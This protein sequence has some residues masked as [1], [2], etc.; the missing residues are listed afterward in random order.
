MAPP[1]VNTPFRDPD[2]GSRMVRVTDANTLSEYGSNFT[3]LSFM[4]D[5]SQEQ[6]T[7]GVFDPSLGVSGG[8]RFVVAAI[9][10]GIVPYTLD[11]TTMNVSRLS[12]QPGS[13]LN[14]YGTFDFGSAAFSYVNPDILYGVS[15]TRLVAY[16]FSIGEEPL[17]YDFANCPGLPSYVSQPWMYPGEP[18]VSTDDTKF[19]DYFG[20]VDQGD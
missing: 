8:Y 13:Y 2:F 16:N 20:G 9:D 19:S 10:G 6:N 14:T 4:T 11:A 5:S 1:A 7:W 3:A 17:V 18:N 15:G 12:G